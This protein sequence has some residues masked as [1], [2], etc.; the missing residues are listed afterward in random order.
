MRIFKLFFILF[1]INLHFAA[2]A[3]CLG[4]KSNSQVYSV[5]VIPQ[6]TASHLHANWAPF[7]EKLGQ[8]SRL[9]FELVIPK[10]ISAFEAAITSG[11]A[12]F[13]YMNPY[14]PVMVRK[15]QP[16]IPLVADGKNKL[17]GILLVRKDSPIQSVADLKGATIAFPTPNAFGASLLM[18]S[19]LAKQ[20]VKINPVYVR[21]TEN[22][23]RSVALGDM[24]AGAGGTNT[25]AR[26]P[27]ELQDQ[28]RVLYATPAFTPHPFAAHAKVPKIIREQ[29]INAFL[30]M[31]ADVANKTMLNNIQIEQPVA[32]TYEHDY[33]P[34]AQLGLEKLVETIEK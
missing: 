25:L 11:K 29:V 6:L 13:A 28:L 10:D 7:L 15:T 32:V 21:T 18:R 33:A 34:L 23:Y 20:G 31:G 22:V 26:E 30:A 8:Q 3:T 5:Y 24:L 17:S 12:D 14:H 4:D 16:Y 9:C 27:K 1:G 19:A 2:S